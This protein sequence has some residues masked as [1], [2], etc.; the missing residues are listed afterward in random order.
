MSA[1]SFR[2]SAISKSNIEIQP[3]KRAKV[4]SGNSDMLSDMDVLFN[5]N[6]DE[7]NKTLTP[8]EDAIAGE[9]CP[10]EVGTAEEKSK[11]QALA[12]K[13]RS[14]EKDKKSPTRR[15]TRQIFGQQPQCLGYVSNPKR[16][17]SKLQVT[18]ESV[19]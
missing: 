3:P 8:D 18:Y 13:G 15:S 4:L 19:K 9:N 12:T 2:I 10:D 1:T 16:S 6:L 7:L 14:K 5:E 11:R 17:T